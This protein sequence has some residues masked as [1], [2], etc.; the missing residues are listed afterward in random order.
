MANKWKILHRPLDVKL[1]FRDSVI[2]A[3]CIHHNY[4]HL[5]DGVNYEDMLHECPLPSTNPA[6]EQ[7]S[8]GGVNTRDYLANYFTSSRV[9]CLAVRKNMNVLLC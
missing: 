6:K 8:Q 4:V 3:C 5:G 1:E 7:G 9:C 2:K